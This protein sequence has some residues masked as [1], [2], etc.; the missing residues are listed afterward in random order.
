MKYAF[1]LAAL[2]SL[3]ALP[4]ISLAQGSMM[5]ASNMVTIDLKPQHNSGESGT[6]TLEQKGDN[7]VVTVKMKNP[8]SA[9]QPIHIHPGT[10]ANLNPK[11]KYPLKNVVDGNSTTTLSGMKLSELETGDFAINVHKSAADIKDYVACGDIPK[12]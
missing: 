8:T 12:K 3:C 1:V 10:C 11:P 7:V 6:A 4:A 2:V 9:S 5:S